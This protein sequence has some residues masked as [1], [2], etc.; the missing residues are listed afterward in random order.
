[1]IK[2]V[3]LGL[4]EVGER[5]AEALEVGKNECALGGG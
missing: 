5:E 3:N 1:M 4:L 2:A